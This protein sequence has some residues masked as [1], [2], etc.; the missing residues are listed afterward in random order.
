MGKRI[1]M[2]D[3][4]ALLASVNEKRIGTKTPK[5]GEPYAF[6]FSQ[7]YGGIKLEQNCEGGGVRTVSP[8]GY[9][10]KRELYLFM[11]GMV[12]SL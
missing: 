3:L 11:R 10:T 1:T 7:A 8:N 12:T 4:N 5:H 2:S 6:I 9:G